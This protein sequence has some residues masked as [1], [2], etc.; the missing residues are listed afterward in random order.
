MGGPSPCIFCSIVRGEVPSH[1]IREGGRCVAFLDVNPISRGHALVVPRAH[2][3]DLTQVTVEDWAEATHL[4]RWVALRLRKVLT[5][6]GNNLFVASGSA[7]EQSV[8]HLHIHVIPRY[9][10]DGLD[11]NEW[12]TM[13]VRPIP[14]AELGEI[15]SNLREPADPEG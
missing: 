9:A 1:R 5:A 12:W 15:A 6:Q 10:G 2:V 8:K 13:K 3:A 4:A 14:S 11:I 7:A